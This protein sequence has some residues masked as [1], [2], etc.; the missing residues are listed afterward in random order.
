MNRINEIVARNIKAARLNRKMSQENLSLLSGLDRTYISG[1]ESGK[2][3]PTIKTL[4]L[5]SLSLNISICEL[6]KDESNE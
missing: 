1:L 3:N 6:V 2:R 5:I 4:Y